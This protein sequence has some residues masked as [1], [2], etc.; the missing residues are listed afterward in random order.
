MVKVKFKLVCSVCAMAWAS[1]AA[2]QQSTFLI[3]SKQRAAATKK[4]ELIA[5]SLP[6][7]RSFTG[8]PD[9]LPGTVKVTTKAGVL[10]GTTVTDTRHA[11]KIS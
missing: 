1:P 8:Q 2:A 4:V 5:A 3:I 11:G 6:P 10:I 9:N 7:T